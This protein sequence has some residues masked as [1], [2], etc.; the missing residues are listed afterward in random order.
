MVIQGALQR[1]GKETDVRDGQK[2]LLDTPSEYSETKIRKVSNRTE[3]HARGLIH[4]LSRDYIVADL[5]QAHGSLY[6]N[7]RQRWSQVQAGDCISRIIFWE[8]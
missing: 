4:R 1:E 2:V 7:E 8:P 5:L 3:F 6:L